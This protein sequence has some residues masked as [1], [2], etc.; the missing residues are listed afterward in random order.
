MKKRDILGDD[1]INTI[2]VENIDKDFDQI[3]IIGDVKE[4]KSK[5]FFSAIGIII[6]TL[7]LC[8]V[9]L[10]GIYTYINMKFVQGDIEGAVLNVG[11]VSMVEKDYSPNNYIKEGSVVYYDGDGDKLFNKSNEFSVGKVVSVTDNKVNLQGDKGEK[12]YSINK[13]QVQFVLDK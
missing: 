8:T 2:A 13:S 11:G 6:L 4:S 10:A 7:L 5:G 9:V 12:T 3:N 1:S